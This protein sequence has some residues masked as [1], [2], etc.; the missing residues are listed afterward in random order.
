MGQVRTFDQGIA[1]GSGSGLALF[2]CRGGFGVGYMGLLLFEQNFDEVDCQ[3]SNLYQI[4]PLVERIYSNRHDFDPLVEGQ[5]SISSK[6][7]SPL[8]TGPC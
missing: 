2:A 7:N 5:F 3:P 8:C 1:L 6:S 4:G